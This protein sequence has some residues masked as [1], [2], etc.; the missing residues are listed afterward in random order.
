MQ[1]SGDAGASANPAKTATSLFPAAGEERRD[2]NRK[3]QAPM[4]PRLQIPGYVALCWGHAWPAGGCQA[5]GGRD[6]AAVP[7][8]STVRSWALRGIPDMA[9]SKAS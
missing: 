5:V 1:R 3:Q 2:L 8:E 7:L 4:V 6:G 9:P